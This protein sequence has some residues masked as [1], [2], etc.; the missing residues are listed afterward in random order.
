MSTSRRGRFIAG[1][2]ESSVKSGSLIHIKHLGR[3]QW[4]DL[5]CAEVWFPGE[6]H[7]SFWLV[8]LSAC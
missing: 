4:R 2:E 1:K 7:E 5:H 3:E 6:D 8:L